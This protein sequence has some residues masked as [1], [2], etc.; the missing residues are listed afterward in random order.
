MPIF[1]SA[2]GDIPW[3]GMP[4][5]AAA[6]FGG[7]GCSMQEEGTLFRSVT[8]AGSNVGGLTGDYVLASFVLPAGSLDG[9]SM[10]D[11]SAA[12]VIGT[13]LSNRGLQ[14]ESIG[15]T[16]PTNATNK[17]IKIWVG[18]TTA[19][20]GS[21]VSGGTLVADSGNITTV[22]VGWS[23]GA[24]LYKYGA[25][26]SNT[27][28]AIHQP[29]VIG[30]TVSTLLAPTY[31]TL[32]ENANILIAVTGYATTAVADVYHSLTVISGMN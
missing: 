3:F 1:D 19:V 9:V 7:G 10:T 5:T 15:G 6:L 17:R 18:C 2:K 22:S 24:Q 20:V 4:N 29:T 27:Q 8:S 28:V 13:S 16:G 11:Y 14:I 30:S 23:I 26:G 32:N 25:A 31:L 12:G 21:V